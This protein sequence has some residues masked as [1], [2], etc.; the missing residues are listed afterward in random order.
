MG[1]LVLLLALPLAFYL[2]KDDP[3]DI[4]ESPDGDAQYIQP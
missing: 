1:A 3:A 2:I 4:G